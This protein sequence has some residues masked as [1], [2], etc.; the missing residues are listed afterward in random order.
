MLKVLVIEIGDIKIYAEA[1][2]N[3]QAL[4]QTIVAN[5]RNTYMGRRHDD[6]YSD[7]SAVNDD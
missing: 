3:K 4:M 1:E 2:E 5:I 7:I 6:N